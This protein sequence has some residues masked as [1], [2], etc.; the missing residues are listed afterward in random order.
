MPQRCAGDLLDPPAVSKREKN[1][2]FSGHSHGNSEPSDNQFASRTV[3]RCN[4][5]FPWG[6]CF[7]TGF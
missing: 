6:S 1:E 7:S 4:G 3:P 2:A 5:D